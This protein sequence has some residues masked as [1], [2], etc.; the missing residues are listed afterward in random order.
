MSRTPAADLGLIGDDADGAAADAPEADHDVLGVVRQDLEEVAVV[1]HRVDHALDVVRLV[2][3]V[4]Y[5]VVEFGTQPLRVVLAGEDRRIVKVV[6][7]D[8]GQQRAGLRV[9]VVFVRGY[10]I[11]Y[12]APSGMGH[13]AA[14]LLEG[15]V[16]A[17]DG[18]DD[19]GSGDEHL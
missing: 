15:H 1:E 3:C 9:H 19:L 18:F 8:K 12:S 10:E 4:G 7:G 16:F 14:E 2:G 13:R 5:E 6:R 11:G 17:G